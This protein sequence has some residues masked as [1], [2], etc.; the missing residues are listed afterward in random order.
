M[1]IKWEQM[2]EINYSLTRFLFFGV[3]EAIDEAN[4]EA[5][6]YIG[7]AETGNWECEI[8][9][10]KKKQKIGLWSERKGLSTFFFVFRKLPSLLC[11][12]HH[13]IG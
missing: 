6:R 8:R 7:V 2:N 13:I 10:W 12:A 11:S 4:L 5:N 3:E 9:E 1:R